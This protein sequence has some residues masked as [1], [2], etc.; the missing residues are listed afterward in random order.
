MDDRITAAIAN[1]VALYES[2]FRAHRLRFQR[3]GQFWHAIDPAPAWYSD[4]IA[5]VP[6][7]HV[8]TVMAALA[9]RPIASIKDSFADLD[10]S[11]AG[12]CE[13]F[14]AQWIYHPAS[15]HIALRTL[16]WR[17]A[18]TPADM[19]RY[20]ELHGSA[21]SLIDNLLA[22]PALAFY[23][24]K[25][26]IEVLAGVLFN[27]SGPD[28]GISNVFLRDIAPETVRVDLTS[29]ATESYPGRALVGYESGDD[30]NPAL[31]AGFSP[32]GPLRIWVK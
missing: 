28:L 3:K 20:R 4:A 13:L 14:A 32:V 27:Q 25:R 11:P 2:V 24:G 10:L 29:L 9:K 22:D 17:R 26:G 19:A 31:A 7:A 15:D 5:L 12:F 21:D 8:D 1:N 30:L 18:E 6:Y 23:L 16:T